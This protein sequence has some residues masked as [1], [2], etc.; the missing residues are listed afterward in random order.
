[1]KATQTLHAQLSLNRD[2]WCRAHV[3]QRPFSFYHYYR[4]KF[5][6]FSSRNLKFSP[7]KLPQSIVLIR[8]A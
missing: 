3:N 1:M 5:A 8:K 4:G 6:P 2:R 7:V